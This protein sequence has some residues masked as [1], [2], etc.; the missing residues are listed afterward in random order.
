MVI[1]GDGS[2]PLARSARAASQKGCR[3][4]AIRSLS[5]RATRAEKRPACGS[6]MTSMPISNV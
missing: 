1:L 3:L 2:T 6:V 5:L 4:L